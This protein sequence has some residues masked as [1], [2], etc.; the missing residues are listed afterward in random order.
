METPN[1]AGRQSLAAGC[2][3]DVTVEIGVSRPGTLRKTQAK[4]ARRPGHPFSRPRTPPVTPAARLSA[5]LDLMDRLDR[6]LRPADAVVSVWLR[7]RRGLAE[8]DRGAVLDRLDQVLRHRARL[9]WW[10]GAAG[11]ADTARILASAARLVKPG[12]R[13]VYATCSL[14]EA[15]N[16]AQVAQFLA[17]H[18]DFRQVPLAQVAPAQADLDTAGQL[19]LTPARAGVARPARRL[20]RPGRFGIV[21]PTW[22]RRSP[23]AKTPGCRR[24]RTRCRWR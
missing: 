8:A 3:R 12:G 13:L 17:A 15:E 6:D 9:G 11:G 2:R 18:P 14:L 16:G 10:L 22:M 23:A 20:Y 1:Y 5:T 4:A 19:S 21:A 7:E 24:S